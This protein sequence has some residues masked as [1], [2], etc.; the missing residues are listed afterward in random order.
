M[1]RSAALLLLLARLLTADFVYSQGPP[2]EDTE[3][4]ARLAYLKERMA[5]YQLV[6]GADRVAR[7]S[8]PV[9]RWSHPVGMTID[10]ASFVWMDGERPVALG[11]VL[12]LRDG[13]SYGE[14]L[15]LTSERLR[16]TRKGVAAWEPAKPGCEFVRVPNA[17]K[18]ADSA[19]ERMTQ[20]KSLAR[21]FSGELIKG[22]PHYQADSIWRLRMLPKQLVRYG[23]SQ[24]RVVDGVL[25]GFCHDTDV[26]MIL[27]LEASGEKADLA[28]HFA[29]APLC[30]WRGTG[31]CDDKPVWSQ[32]QMAPVN[33]SKQPYMTFIPVP[34]FA[35]EPSLQ[36]AL[37]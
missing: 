28:W 17:P 24:G 32:P 8:P 34:S 4:E 6:V 33:A 2:N 12:V 25:F 35:V 26:E 5:E 22:P 10:G 9:Y 23:D 15:S 13:T 11:S 31:K 27:V 20:M 36:E 37:K 19:A 21:R 16:A 3:R 14:L 18:P 30:G 7:M 1:I 29:F